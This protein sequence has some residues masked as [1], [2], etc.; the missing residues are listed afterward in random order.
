MFV[1]VFLEMVLLAGELNHPGIVGRNVPQPSVFAVQQQEEVL[2]R[3]S[4]GHGVCED[5]IELH[6]ELLRQ[7][8]LL[9]EADILGRL[10]LALALP[11]AGLF[12]RNRFPWY[13]TTSTVLLFPPLGPLSVH[14]RG[15]SPTS[16]SLKSSKKMTL[17]PGMKSYL[18]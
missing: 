7:I 12:L 8:A 13:S 2:V 10:V 11:A 18:E 17:S 4:A 6:G 14:L 5:G 3:V 16:V 1:R 15:N 9:I